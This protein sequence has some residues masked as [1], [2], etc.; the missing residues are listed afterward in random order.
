[1]Q[2]EWDVLA[3]MVEGSSYTEARRQG[4]GGHQGTGIYD[5]RGPVGE[6]ETSDG[7]CHLQ[8]SNISALASP[9]EAE[10]GVQ[11]RVAAR[12]TWV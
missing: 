1:M 9:G 2:G 10:L 3:E 12:Q 8:A 7:D 4:G 11:N 5:I 6:G